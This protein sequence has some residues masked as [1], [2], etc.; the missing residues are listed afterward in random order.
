MSASANPDIITDGLVLCLDAADRKSLLAAPSVN[1]ANNSSEAINWTTSGLG[2]STVSQSTVDVDAY[3]Y[4]FVLDKGGAA[5]NWRIAFDHTN[6][7]DGSTYIISYKY[8]ITSG[9]G[10]FRAS[11]FCDQGI[12]RTTT[13]LADGW[14]YETASGSRSGYSETYD[15]LDMYASDSMT[16]DIKEIQM[17]LTS[18]SSPFATPFM[19]YQRKWQDRA[20]TNDGTP[21]NMLQDSYSSDN[22]GILLLDGTDDSIGL[23]FVQDTS[24]SFSVEVWA[25]S[26]NM[27]TN[28]SNRQT[29]FSLNDGI[30]GYFTLTLEIWGGGAVTFSGNGTNYA[31][32]WPSGVNISNALNDW[33]CYALSCSGGVFTWYLNGVSKSTHTPS[34]SNTSSFFKIA[35]RGSGLT[36]VNQPLNGKISSSKIYNKALTASEVLQNYNATKSR[37]N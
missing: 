29:I 23:A 36:G 1:L 11:D 10:T 27:D 21:N 6:M 25:K 18:S 9:S 28:T 17:E 30:Q 37:F 8:K 24:S 35:S 13:A 26:D 3:H 31:A 33:H 19:P 2:G 22:G 12:T 32:I 7:V 5:M 15:F 20:G 34:Y 14:Y 16:V 4:R